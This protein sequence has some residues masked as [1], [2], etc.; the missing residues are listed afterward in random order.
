MNFFKILFLLSVFFVS[1]PKLVLA[2][3]KKEAVN[4]RACGL[5]SANFDLQEGHLSDYWAQELIGAD[6]LK[7]YI[8]TKNYS[9]RDN[10]IAVFDSSSEDHNVK[11]KS[12]ISDKG[13]H[14]VLPVMA[15]NSISFFQTNSD[16]LYSEVSSKIIDDLRF[17]SFNYNSNNNKNYN[18]F[19]AKYLPAYINN[20]MSWSVSSELYQSIK[21]LKTYPLIVVASGN[22]FPHSL[23]VVKARAEREGIILLV[24]SLS[25]NGL[26]SNFSQRGSEL[27]IL[28]PSGE[29]IISVDGQGGYNR[30][31]GTSAATPLVTASLASFEILSDYHPS[32]EEAKLL[33]EK[34]AIPTIYS[35]FESPRQN[36]AGLLNSYKLGKVA[37]RLNKKCSTQ[38]DFE[39]CMSEEIRKDENYIFDIKQSDLFNQLKESFPVCVG[40]Q[41]VFLNENQCSDMENTFRALRKAVL[42]EPENVELWGILSCVYEQAG[43]LANA[44]ALKNL[45][46]DSKSESLAVLTELSKEGSVLDVESSIQTLK[47]IDK[48]RLDDFL[49][50]LTKHENINVRMMV[51]HLAAQQANLKALKIFN[52]LLR[53]QSWQ[54]RNQLAKSVSHMG[55]KGVLVLQEL[56]KD[57]NRIVRKRVVYSASNIG[58]PALPVLKQLTQDEDEVVSGMAERKLQLI[59]ASL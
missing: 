19:L 59:K 44:E 37:S 24:G 54:V 30:F 45:S 55:A 12:L 5:A 47:N 1:Y 53:D 8:K 7:E 38:R 33:L 46:L 56:S 39:L 9:I 49:F 20:S 29:S 31:G 35:R 3:T 57:Q 52:S 2:K 15:S 13:F 23:N 36:G 17:Q 42:L 58:Y 4:I 6:L 22:S 26:V 34:T 25:S 43:F 50:N 18:E 51:A 40:E 21:S 28:A 27:T 10:F 14:S 32:R 11:V 16:E 41:S 48:S